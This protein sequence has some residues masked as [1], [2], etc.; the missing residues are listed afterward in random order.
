MGKYEAEFQVATTLSRADFERFETLVRK[1]GSNKL[2]IARGALRA[3]LCAPRL[4]GALPAGKDAAEA[5]DDLLCLIVTAA[6][7]A[8][9]GNRQM[10]G[11]AMTYIETLARQGLAY[12][13]LPTDG[14]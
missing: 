4:R 1:S 5:V 9:G 8:G 11:D 7:T 10:H 3:Y 12:L 2:R 6:S 14:R 13:A